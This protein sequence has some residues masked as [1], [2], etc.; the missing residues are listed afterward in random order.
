[1]P[2]EVVMPQMGYDMAEGTLVRWLKHENDSVTANEVIAEIETD[3]AVVEMQ[4]PDDGTVLALLISEGMTVPVGS[5]IAYIGV[6][7]EVLPAEAE[8]P[9]HEDIQEPPPGHQ[10]GGLPQG[11]VTTSQGQGRTRSSP[12]ARKLAIEDAQA[13]VLHHP[14]LRKRD[15][16][17]G[18]PNNARRWLQMAHARFDASQRAHIVCCRQSFRE[19]AYFSRVAK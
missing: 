7:G 5:T 14:E 11:L 18:Q 2:I 4:A 9:D 6:P 13:R 12:L 17:V 15:C 1:M 16:Q 3:K 19:R 10:P 8:Q